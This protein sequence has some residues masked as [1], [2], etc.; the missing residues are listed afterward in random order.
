MLQQAAKVGARDTVLILLDTGASIDAQDEAGYT[1][2][3]YVTENNRT[4]T[5]RHLL[6]KVASTKI[7]D[8][9]G[10]TILRLV[11]RQCERLKHIG[12]KIMH[13]KENKLERMFLDLMK[14]PFG[15]EPGFVGGGNAKSMFTIR[16]RAAIT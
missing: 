4:V 7:R 5:L 13:M 15:E 14:S 12:A 10:R 3:R 8:C 16:G 6:I 11:K 9:D 2:A 1:A